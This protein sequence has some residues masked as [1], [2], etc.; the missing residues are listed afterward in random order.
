MTLRAGL[1]GFGLA[2]RVFHMPLLLEAGIEIA[3]IVTRQTTVIAELFPSMTAVSD[4]DSMLHQIPLDLVVIATPNQFHAPQALTALRAGKHV[5]GDKPMSVNSGEAD[6]LVQ[7]AHGRQRLVMPFHNR[8]WDSDFLTVK[9]LL[10][11]RELGD[12]HR[13]EA[14]WDRNR[15]EVVDRWRE[16]ANAG[17]GV[18]NDLG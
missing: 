6:A 8:R 16:R 13:Y 14:R 18:L 2:G 10:V 15:P 17:G 5:V 7:E 4:V 11:K 1:V 12:V 9:Y 3:A